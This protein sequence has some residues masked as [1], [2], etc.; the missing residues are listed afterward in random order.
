MKLV[1]GRWDA[2]VESAS[3]GSSSSPDTYGTTSASTRTSSQGIDMIDGQTAE[4]PAPAAEC[5]RA[6][7]RR[8]KAD[9]AIP[10]P[11]FGGQ[12]SGH[13]RIYRRVIGRGG[14][15]PAEDVRQ[16]HRDHRG[17]ADRPECDYGGRRVL[18]DSPEGRR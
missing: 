7:R 2:P 6:S 16:A 14:L 4:S 1:A 18:R 15:C 13:R 5:H 9:E 8:E 12:R 10:P 11:R 3:G 17:P